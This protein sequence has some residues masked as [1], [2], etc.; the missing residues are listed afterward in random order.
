MARNVARMFAQETHWTNPFVNNVHHVQQQVQYQRKLVI[1][2]TARKHT[3]YHCYH[4][5]K[6]SE[7]LSTRA[8]LHVVGD[9][10]VYVLDISQP[11]L[12]TP[13]ILFLCLFLFLWLFQLYF[14]P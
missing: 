3:P 7:I 12:P 6:Y 5:I 2:S 11:S 1:E 4:F 13:F 10:T 8:H 9:A 14:I